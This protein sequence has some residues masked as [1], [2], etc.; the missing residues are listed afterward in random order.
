MCLGASIILLLA[1][2]HPRYASIISVSFF[3]SSIV[4]STILRYN[5]RIPNTDGRSFGST[6]QPFVGE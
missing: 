2:T 1:Q 3:T 4:A 5:H 6:G